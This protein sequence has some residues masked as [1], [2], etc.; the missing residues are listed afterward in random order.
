[1]RII[2]SVCGPRGY[3]AGACRKSV[4]GVT[5]VATTGLAPALLR[6]VSALTRA[7]ASGEALI[8]LTICAAVLAILPVASV[9]RLTVIAL[10]DTAMAS[11]AFGAPGSLNCAV[12]LLPPSCPQALEV[13]TTAWPRSS[14]RTDG[15][16]CVGRFWLATVPPSYGVVVPRIHCE[17]RW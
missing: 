7:E 4:S 17:W 14:T 15:G 12:M 13:S 9:A 3:D 10:P 6:Y 8:A 2:W 5:G 11:G 16:G 1:M